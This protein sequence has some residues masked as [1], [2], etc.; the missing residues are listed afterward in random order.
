MLRLFCTQCNRL[1]AA[2]ENPEQNGQYAGF[3]PHC[4]TGISPHRYIAPGTVINGFQVAHEIGRGGMGV[5]YLARQL[6][7]D[8]DAALKILSDEMSSDATFV[9]AFFREARSAAALNHP[10]IVLAY[11]AGEAPDQIYYF[12]ME[13]IEG[14]NLEVYTAQ[15][16]ALPQDLAIKCATGIADALAYAWNEK[17]LAHRDIKPENII[18]TKDGKFKLADLGLA[19]AYDGSSQ[20]S[21]DDGMATPAYASPEVIRHETDKIGFKSDIYSFGATLYQL[22]TGKPPFEDSDPMVI[23]DKQLNE[24]PK[25][26]IGVNP[27]LPS[28]LSMLVDKMMEKAPG[29]RPE[30]W[31]DILRN[32]NEIALEIEQKSHGDSFT[33]NPEPKL[34]SLIPAETKDH[35]SRQKKDTEKHKSKVPL[36][37]GILIAV[38]LLSATGLLLIHEMPPEESKETGHAVTAAAT[39]TSDTSAA[40]NRKSTK[41][42][43]PKATYE[44]WAALQKFRGIDEADKILDTLELH[45]KNPWQMQFRTSVKSELAKN[46]LLESDLN[47]LVSMKTTAD[48]LL[49]DAQQHPVW[50]QESITEEE[51]AA[52]Q[53]RPAEI[54]EKI[55]LE[56]LALR[57]KQEWLE[58]EQ[59][60]AEREKLF[61]SI[62]KSAERVSIPENPEYM[63]QEQLESALKAHKQWIT[64]T[65]K[66]LSGIREIPKDVRKTSTAIRQSH[67]KLAAQIQKRKEQHQMD[68][69]KEHMLKDLESALQK[70]NI[71]A[72]EAL[73]ENLQTMTLT[74]SEKDMLA[75]ITEI[76]RLGRTSL[77]D[78]LINAQK[79]LKGTT[80]FPESYPGYTMDHVTDEKIYFWQSESG[81][82]ALRS[83]PCETLDKKR[84]QLLKELLLKSDVFTKNTDS[85]FVLAVFYGALL[86]G[87]PEKRLLQVARKRL[88]ECPE[89]QKKLKK[90]LQ[91]FQQDEPENNSSR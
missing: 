67:N 27:A 19:K 10:N 54:A 42:N 58:Q 63:T 65:N 74:E 3:C 76:L 56:E 85:G 16:G 33:E 43:L 82:K 31:D 64:A 80:P 57:K 5:V 71:T 11:N 36:I 17:R 78:L 12:A 48:T 38:L 34:I 7:L 70:K 91:Y 1:V 2:T 21:A 59:A 73:I 25:P 46:V 14:E 37:A 40:D 52:L 60:D 30:S 83:F 68:Q 8:R 50:A 24:Q 47:C 32:L 29:K 20:E 15:H 22:F 44:R 77:H 45:A 75:E 49:A 90:S 86:D 55:Q 35:T 28:K 4:G 89:L 81:Y 6:D 9:N 39:E 23:C 87:A 18:F 66:K 79:K 51:Y 62:L 88:Q 69:Q 41:Y 53:K 72:A 26:L 13:L 84:E 61:Q